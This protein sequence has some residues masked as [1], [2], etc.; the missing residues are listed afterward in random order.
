MQDTESRLPDVWL[1]LFD[2]TGL[3]AKQDTSAI[4]ATVGEDGWP[5]VSFLSVGEVLVRDHDRLS[6]LLWPS[7]TTAGNLRRTGRAILFAAAEGS[8]WEAR[9]DARPTGDD[10][11]G[12]ARFDAQ[13]VAVRRHVAPYAEVTGMIGFRLH[14]PDDVIARWHKQIE[15]LA[16]PG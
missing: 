4:L 11:Q 8:V 14:D 3:E 13:A 16:H 5:H 9:L 15:R 6:L 10:G 1:S 7:S 2:G 12:L